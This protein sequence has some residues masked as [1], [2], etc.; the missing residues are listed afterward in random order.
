ML[1]IVIILT[2]VKMYKKTT[3]LL[4]HITIEKLIHMFYTRLIVKTYL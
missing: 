1:G 3:R 2:V 4:E